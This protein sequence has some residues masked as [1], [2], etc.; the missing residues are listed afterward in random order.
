MYESSVVAEGMLLNPIGQEDGE[1][2]SSKILCSADSEPTT[3]SG[4]KA[5]YEGID[6]RTDFKQYMQSYAGARGPARGPR[7]EGPYEEGFVSALMTI[8]RGKV[9]KLVSCPACRLTSNE[10]RR[11]L[12]ATP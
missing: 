1:S 4:L 9:L 11:T 5:M 6:N 2:T 10:A 7:R 8:L 3:G 12:Q